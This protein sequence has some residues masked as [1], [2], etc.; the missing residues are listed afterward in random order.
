EFYDNR[1]VQGLLFDGK[2]VKGV[3]TD[4][5]VLETDLVVD[6]TG[7]GS[8]SPQWLK[9]IGF[10]P[11]LEEKVEVQL[12]Y[13]T[14]LFK[15]SPSDLGGDMI[16]AIPPTPDGKRGGVMLAQE[17]GLWITTLYGYF[18]HQAPRDLDGYVKYTKTLPAP[19]IHDVIR[20]AVPVGD[21]SFIR[22]PASTRR[23]YENLVR[24]P[25]G[26]LVFGDAI[27]SFNP[28]YG[29]GMS[30]AALQAVE[31]RD[32]LAGGDTNFANRFFKRTAK[33]IDI[34]WNISVGS[35]LRMPETI[36]TRGLGVKLINWYMSKLH[37]CAHHDPV[38]ASAFIRVA[39]LLATPDSLMRPTM[40]WRV[41]SSDIRSRFGLLDAKTARE[42][43]FS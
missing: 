14:R 30:V 9:S 1:T 17:N 29:Q 27:C 12:T 32:Q 26:F 38:A 35:E 10:E 36:G 28:I 22:F 33:M 3:R 41:F 4:A 20:N 11:P 37:K 19:Y 18:G 2:V 5:G 13:T 31:L 15:R 8:R 7:R 34:P 16:V 43:T 39:Q 24:F 25:S 42:A 23:R 6:T 21:A 40:L